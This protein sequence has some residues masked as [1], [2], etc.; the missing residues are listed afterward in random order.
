MAIGELAPPAGE[1]PAAEVLGDIVGETA[2]VTLVA[3]PLL[4]AMAKAMALV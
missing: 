3:I 4:A 1:V 2:G